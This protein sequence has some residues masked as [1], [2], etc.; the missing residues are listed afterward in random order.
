MLMS[1]SRAHIPHIKCCPMVA[2]R[3]RWI[4]TTATCIALPKASDCG[5]VDALVTKPNV[6]VDAGKARSGE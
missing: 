5:T 1:C 3:K 4:T 6:R 2:F